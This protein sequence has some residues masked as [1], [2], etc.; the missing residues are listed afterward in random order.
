MG[1]FTVR[2][3]AVSGV[4]IALSL[5]ALLI[6]AIWWTKSLIRHRRRVALERAHG[7]GTSPQA[8]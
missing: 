7:V 2:S 5:G 8:S 3:R 6:L 4:A 1:I